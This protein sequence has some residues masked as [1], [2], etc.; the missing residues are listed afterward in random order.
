MLTTFM[1]KIGKKR[2]HIKSHA[3]KILIN[4]ILLFFTMYLQFLSNQRTSKN[5]AVKSKGKKG[6]VRRIKL[7][8]SSADKAKRR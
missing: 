3:R 4:L 2:K 7:I 6:A 1:L 5:V 8:S